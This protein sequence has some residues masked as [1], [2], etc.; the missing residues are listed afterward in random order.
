MPRTVRHSGRSRNKRL[1]PVITSANGLIRNGAR[2]SLGRTRVIRRLVA[3]PATAMPSITRPMFHGSFFHAVKRTEPIEVPSTIATNVLI[4]SN[5]L[6]RDRSLSGSNSGTM[7]YFAGLKTVECRAIR[8][9]TANISSIRV[10]KNAASPSPI[11]AISK[12]FTEIST[13]RLL[14]RSAMCPEYT[15]NS[16]NGST[17]TAPASERYSPPPPFIAATCTA[18][19]ETI[20]L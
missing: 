11:T 6:A 1:V 8:K 3:K 18:R 5:P 20:I 17:K 4:S 13:L 7:P 9:R 12:T 2:T 14:K 19:I 15:E 10:V 16:R